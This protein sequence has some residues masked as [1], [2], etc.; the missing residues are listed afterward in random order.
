MT[1]P[2][3]KGAL[4]RPTGLGRVALPAAEGAY[5]IDIAGGRISAIRP[6]EGPPE[7]LLLPGFANMH[8][9][10]ERSFSAGPAPASLADAIRRMEVVRKASSAADFRDRTARLLSRAL[11]HGTLRLR[12]HTDIDDLVGWRA[13]EGVQAA[14]KAFADRVS[15]EIV[16]FASSRLDPAMPEGRRR[17]ADALDRGAHLLGAAPALASDP[18]AALA[19]ILDVARAEGVAVDLHLDE[20]GVPGDALIGFLI[21]RVAAMGLE[22]RVTIS[23]NC[24]LATLPPDR[25][26]DIVR[27]LAELRLTVV[28]LP[29]TNLYLQDR[30]AGTPSRRGLTLVK[31]LLAAGVPVWFG[32]DNVRDS[33]YPYGDADP[34]ED[35]FLVSLAAHVDEPAALLAGLSAGRGAPAPGDSAD[36]VLVRAHSLTDALARRPAQRLVLRGG[37]VVAA[38]LDAEFRPASAPGPE[39][40]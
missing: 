12:T 23:H 19:S 5:D 6:G 15:V 7:W 10:A 30:S 34:L 27:R 17:L 25:G 2:R 18:R 16:A 35:A 9:H 37:E 31:E 13:L 21:E 29:G 14:C 28:V 3:R 36:I 20:H 22:G 39:R 1:D 4:D 32:S 38:S 11:M 26:R 40:R 33:F 8:V 24:A